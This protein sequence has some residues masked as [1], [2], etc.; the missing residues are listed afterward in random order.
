MVGKT[1]FTQVLRYSQVILP[2]QCI[3]SPLLAEGSHLMAEWGVLLEI[4][5][6]QFSC[7]ILLA[8]QDINYVIFIMFY[9][10]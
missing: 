1:H 10:G 8:W 2:M 3:I 4:D 7:S 5:S 6:A 9:S